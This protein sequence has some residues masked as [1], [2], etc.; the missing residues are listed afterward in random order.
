MPASI[1]LAFIVGLL[2]SPFGVE[3]KDQRL[4]V[5]KAEKM[6]GPRVERRSFLRT[7]RFLL[8]CLMVEF[9]H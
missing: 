2:P 7:K 6:P 9:H 1:W 8:H 5:A 3:S 4:P